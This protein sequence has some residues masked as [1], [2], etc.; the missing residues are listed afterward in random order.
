[1]SNVKVPVG[2]VVGGPEDIAGAE[3][4]KDYDALPSGVPAYI[5]SRANG[6]HQTV[7]IEPA[8]LPEDA[9]IALN[10]LD[11]ALFGNE[12][13]LEALQ[14]TPCEACAPGLWTPRAKHLETLTAR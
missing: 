1:M 4:A 10:W 11:L 12:D 2:Y 9:E 6:D 13:A 7:S 5:A 14:T 3:A 8:I